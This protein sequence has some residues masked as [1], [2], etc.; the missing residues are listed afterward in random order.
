MSWRSAFFH[1]A[2]SDRAIGKMLNRQ[3][4]PYCHQLHY[5]Q[6]AA[7]KLAKAY[8]STFDATTP[9]PATHGVIVRLLQVIKQ[10]PDVRRRLGYENQANLFNK[11]IDSLLPLAHRIEQLAP[12]VAMIHTPNPEYPWLDRSIGQVLA[13]VD[14]H[15]PDLR[16]AD[17]AMRKM[18]ILIDGLLRVFT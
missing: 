4:A 9:P 15:F 2:A 8:L 12:S 7:E 17:P 6:M 11:F 16:P 14:Y 5:L 13:P 1:Q 3:R 10:R 18:A